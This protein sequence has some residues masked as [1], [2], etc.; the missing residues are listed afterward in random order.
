MIATT[1]SGFMKTRVLRRVLS[2]DEGMDERFLRFPEQDVDQLK[3]IDAFFHKKDDLEA[4]KTN[5]L[6]QRRFVER[7]RHGSVKVYDLLQGGLMKEWE[8][9]I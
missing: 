7:E 1:V 2:A 6:F 3:R 8:M 9:E 4:L 5:P